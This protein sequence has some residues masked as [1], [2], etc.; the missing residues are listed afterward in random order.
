[1]QYNTMQYNRRRLVPR[2]ITMYGFATDDPSRDESITYHLLNQRRL[3]GDLQLEIGLE[4]I[5]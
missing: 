1:M 5:G 2:R 3:L 4:V